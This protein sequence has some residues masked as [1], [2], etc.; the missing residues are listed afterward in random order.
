VLAGQFYWGDNPAF[1]VVDIGGA[2]AKGPW[3]LRLHV[4]NLF[5]EEYYIDAQEFPNFG[6]SATPGTPGSIII[7]TLEQPRRAV[8]SASYAF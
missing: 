4:E 7:G 6:G 5:D 2:L 8:L 3:E 1:T